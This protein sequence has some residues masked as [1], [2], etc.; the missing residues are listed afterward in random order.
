VPISLSLRGTRS[1]AFAIVLAGAIFRALLF[2]RIRE[3]PDVWGG[4]RRTYLEIL[5]GLARGR[6]LPEAWIWPPG[7]PLLGLPLQPLLGAGISLQVV[8]FLAG[9]GLLVLVLA[10]GRAI[11]RPRLGAVA[12]AILAFHPEAA[13]ASA[14][15]LSEAPAVLL[16]VVTAMGLEA[17]CRSRRIRWAILAGITGALAVLTRPELAVSVAAMGVVAWL[18]AGAARRAV[19]TSAVVAVL[20]MSPYVLALHAAS[21]AWSLSLKP[22]VNVLKA[23]VYEKGSEFAER[24][25]LWDADFARFLDEQGELDPRRLAEA[26]SPAR[27]VL[28][29]ETPKRWALHVADA[30]RRNRVTVDIVWVLGMVGLLLPGRRDR[31]RGLV[32]ASAASFAVI[33]LLFAP[34][35][36][37]GLVAAPAFAWGTALLI[38]RVSS[39][40]RDHFPR[41]HR[42]LA[43]A[44]AAGL[45][46]LG[47]L[48]ALRQT[49]NSHWVG[50]GSEFLV[51]LERNDLAAA[52]RLVQDGLRVDPGNPRIRE[53]LGTLR[54]RQG[55]RSAAIRAYEEAGRL[56][57][58]PVRLAALLFR[59]GEKER[60]ETLIAP[61]R[62]SPPESAEYRAL[63]GNLAFDRGEWDSA[64][65]HFRRAAELGAPPDRMALN[66]A[67]CRIRQGR[68]TEAEALLSAA[69]RSPDPSIRREAMA[70]LRRFHP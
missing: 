69:A 16:L 47:V 39:W 59:A 64:A 35:H 8:S 24:R 70:E 1:A 5:D 26:A 63:E 55:D 58:D 34:V 30:F 15:A 49:D 17:T 51:E 62:S 33:P 37:Y 53:A 6:L 44:A 43:F 9:V 52:E 23:G 10:A 67:I 48:D 12:A 28:S 19:T 61:L 68:A 14:R 13:V 3:P 38:L 11:G 25:V 45:C 56:G 57:G 22:H 4:D 66:E 18:G 20:A 65:R 60:A 32:I 54:E 40:S 7:Y 27:Y 31:V 42:T 50:R 41:A 2:L 21:G 46:G 29:A 36:R